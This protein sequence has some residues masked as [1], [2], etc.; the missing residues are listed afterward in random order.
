MKVFSQNEL[1]N[2]EK[3][4]K[5]LFIGNS[6]TYRQNFPNIFKKLAETSGEQLYIDKAT[7]PGASLIELYEEIETLEKIKSEKWDYVVIQERTIKS[8]Q[9]DISEFQQGANSIYQKIKENNQGTKIIYN[10]VGVYNDFDKQQQE[11]TNN[12]YEQIAEITDGIVSYSG[13]ASLIFHI[14]FPDIDLYED[15]Q[16]SSLVGAY[17]NA[18]CLYDTI[19][20]R[21]SSNVE[22]YDV[23]NPKI[24]IELQRV[25]DETMKV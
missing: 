9:E 25:A 18:C 8:L 22:Y 20:R 16:H 11:T 23:L 13:S 6:K 24:A 7:K 4:I 21:A 5:I 14:K 19:Y 12:H 15:K 3:E 17:L 1:K 10:A 2:R